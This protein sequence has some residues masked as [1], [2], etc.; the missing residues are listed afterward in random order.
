MELGILDK[1]RQFSTPLLSDALDTLGLPGGLLGIRPMTLLTTG[2]MVGPAYTVQFEKVPAGTPAIAADYIDEVPT[3]WTVVLA[4]ARRMDCSVWGGILT[5]RAQTLGL[6]G[7][8]IDGCFRDV[9]DI[10]MINYPV[11]ARDIYMRSGKNRAQMVAQHV[12]VEISGVVIQPEDII[13]GDENGVLV[14]PRLHLAEV[15]A[16]AQ[17]VRQTEQSI[18]QHV[19]CGESLR[20]ARQKFNYNRHAVRMVSHPS[21]HASDA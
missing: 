7:T 15:L 1:V 3:G 16:Q 18:L 10:R 12:P 13:V 5:A 19:Q 8:V 6:C 14:I 2:L 17:E 21:P 4:N 11:F 20:A 9:G